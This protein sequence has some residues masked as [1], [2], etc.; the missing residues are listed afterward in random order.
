M[1]VFFSDFY[2]Q[3]FGVRLQ[4]TLIAP[5]GGNHAIYTDTR[6][7]A[8]F[9]EPVCA[10]I[11]KNLE[12]FEHY[13]RMINRD[14]QEFVR[15]CKE[16]GQ[17]DFAN[18][19]RQEIQQWYEQY[20]AIYQQFFYTAIWIPF[21]TEPLLSEAGKSRLEAL[22][23]N[24]GQEKRTQEFFDV[25][26]SPEQKNAVTREREEL[27]HIVQALE[28]SQVTADEAAKRL[29]QHAEQYCWIPCYDIMD[30]AWRQDDF[31]KQFAEARKSDWKSEIALY[32][33]FALRHDRFMQTLEVLDCSEVD[34]TLFTIC[35]EMTFIKDER[36]DY[37][38]Q[39]SYAIQPF[40]VE[41]GK[42]MGNF[43][44]REVAQ[45]LSTEVRQYFADGILPEAE[46]IHERVNGYV[47]LRKNGEENIHIFSGTEA[48]Q[49]MQSELAHLQ[50]VATQS[51]RGTVGSVGKATGVAKRVI[52]KHDLRKVNNGD[53]VIAVTTHPDFVPAMR[54]A[55]AIVT[56]EGGVTSHAAIVS[57]ELH[58][59]CIVGTKAATST[60]ADGDMVEVDAEKG[61]AKKV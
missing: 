10:K 15:V 37:R 8:E 36:D 22:L 49:V 9:A 11:S 55:A 43:S 16:I 42:R 3:E 14:Q 51:V 54:R 57:R 5:K 39:G 45:L 29:Q 50:H 6:E 19:S 56:D 61:I 47:L 25:I 59:P 23:K 27:L 1:R 4:N 12:T 24:N 13:K 52:T 30:A 48:E 33:D 38:R 32:A 41:L 35:H 28:E 7:W 18:A 34:R 20:Q 31:V 2:K 17:K 58:I 60:F 21:T 46:K 40:F 26:F 44:V 53:I